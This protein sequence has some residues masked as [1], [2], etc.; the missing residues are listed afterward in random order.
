M[1]VANFRSRHAAG[2]T[3]D[4]KGQ[5][6]IPI[7]YHGLEKVYLV[8]LPGNPRWDGQIRSKW[9]LSVGYCIA[10]IGKVWQACNSRSAASHA[11]CMCVE[12]IS[13]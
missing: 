5:V 12:S 13:Q 11:D 8:W 2:S 3:K 6:I 7:V 1:T 9:I 4:M 10:Y